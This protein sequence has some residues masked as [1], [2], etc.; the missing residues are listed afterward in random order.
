MDLKFLAPWQPQMLSILRIMAALLFIEHGTVKL[1]GWPGPGPASLATLYLVA[2]LIETIGGVLLTVG[3]FT[4]LCAF[5]MSGEMA[6]AYFMSHA[7]KS[8]YPIVNGGDGAILY[9]FIFLY[10]AVAGGGA[11]SLDRSMRHRD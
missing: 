1:F 6:F 2:A 4:R 10:I 11:W 8:I 7:P 5:I 3:L 9:C